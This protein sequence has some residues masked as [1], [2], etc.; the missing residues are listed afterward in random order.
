VKDEAII[1]LQ[2]LGIS[3]RQASEL[4]RAV[5]T[6][7][8]NDSD[9]NEIVKAAFQLSM[10]NT[11]DRKGRSGKGNSLEDERDLRLIVKKGKDEGMTA[12]EALKQAGVIRLDEWCVG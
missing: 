12:Y 2:L 1:R 9:V 6:E 11:R 10:G 7:Q 5:L 4:V 8:P 3:E